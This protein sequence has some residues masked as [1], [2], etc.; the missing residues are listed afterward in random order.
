MALYGMAFTW[1]GDEWRLVLSNEAPGTP[2][3]TDFLLSKVKG[4]YSLCVEQT[5]AITK[6]LF[7][8]RLVFQDPSN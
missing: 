7:S 3:L 5:A 1:H 4:K 2:A 8:L 6:S